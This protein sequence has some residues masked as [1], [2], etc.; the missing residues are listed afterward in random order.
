MTTGCTYC[1]SVRPI[2]AHF[3]TV[4]PVP[5]TIVIIKLAR[6]V[7]IRDNTCMRIHA[8][9]EAFRCCTLPPVPRVYH[10]RLN[11]DPSLHPL[12][13]QGS[14]LRCQGAQV[15]R[16]SIT[17]AHVMSELDWE[18]SGKIEKSGAQTHYRRAIATDEDGT[19]ET[20]NI[21]DC[22]YMRGAREDE[23]WVGV[24]LDLYEDSEKKGEERLRV[25]LRWFYDE[26]YLD[27]K[28]KRHIGVPKSCLENELFFA[29]DVSYGENNLTY[30]LGKAY[31]YQDKEEFLKNFEKDDSCYLVRCFYSP[32]LK[33]RPRLR[34]LETGELKFLLNNPTTEEMY[35]RFAK[36]PESARRKYLASSKMEE[37]EVEDEDEEERYAV[38]LEDGDAAKSLKQ[39][40]KIQRASKSEVDEEKPPERKKREGP[41]VLE[42]M[43]SKSQRLRRG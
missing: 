28:T 4:G 32:F 1:N 35:N 10:T 40:K 18:L 12:F 38:E 26:V 27:P 25:I 24:I 42:V 2:A 20:Y 43:F 33:H 13:F 3:V 7:I 22:A 6:S 36:A 17:R 23:W 14:T 30:L 19:K 37:I 8:N 39:M 21:G 29:D 9:L 16:I 34:L 41:S 15:R 11:H 31:L 5:D